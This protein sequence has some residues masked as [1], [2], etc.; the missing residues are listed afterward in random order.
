MSDAGACVGARTQ[1]ASRRDFRGEL[2]ASL[3][4]GEGSVNTVTPAR[5][6]LLSGGDGEG[7]GLKKERRWERTVCVLEGSGGQQR[8]STVAHRPPVACG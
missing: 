2:G 6:S 4:S 8:Q 7:A 1:G 5:L 3:L